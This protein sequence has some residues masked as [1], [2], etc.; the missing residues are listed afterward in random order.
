[1]IQTVAFPNGEVL[2]VAGLKQLL[3]E[4]GVE[5]KV[6]TVKTS[7]QGEQP[8]RSIT[9]RSDGGTPLQRVTK[10]EDFGINVYAEDYASASTLASTVEALIQAL[11]K[12]STQIKN[13]EIRSAATRINDDGGEEQRYI[14]ATVVIKGSDLIF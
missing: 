7:P 1:M 3:S 13:V 9:V 5:A 6:S 2:V 4:L 12:V 14:R 11:P 10:E 8:R